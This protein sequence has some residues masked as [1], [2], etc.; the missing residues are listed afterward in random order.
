MFNFEENMKIN[1]ESSYYY[2]VL[3]YK[4]V[5]LF[6]II[7]FKIILNRERRFVIRSSYYSIII[8][9]QFYSAFF[10]FLSRNISILYS[11]HKNIFK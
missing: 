6:Y 1:G 10:E 4:F 5:D 3:V 7:W 11:V 9:I 8:S 2:D